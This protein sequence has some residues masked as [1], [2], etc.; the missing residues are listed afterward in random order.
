MQVSVN[1][2]WVI[3]NFR[4]FERPL[5]N[6]NSGSLHF[7]GQPIDLADVAAYDRDSSSDPAPAFDQ[8]KSLDKSANQPEII[9]KLKTAETVFGVDGGARSSL[10]ATQKRTLHVRGIGTLREVGL[11]E[12]NV[13]LFKPIGNTFRFLSQEPEESGGEGTAPPSLTYLSVGV[14]SLPTG[15]NRRCHAARQA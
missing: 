9:V 10:K 3:G 14:G 5:S 1:S 11:K 2:H 15:I 13:Q 8:L 6:K 7:N 4:L 12:V